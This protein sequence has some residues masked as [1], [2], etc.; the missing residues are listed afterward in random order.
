MLIARAFNRIYDLKMTVRG[1]MEY[2]YLGENPPRSGRMVGT[3]A[4]GE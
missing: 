2:A 3:M 4:T 1:E